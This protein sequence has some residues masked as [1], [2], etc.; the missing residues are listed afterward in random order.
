MR[1]R[2]FRWFKLEQIYFL[3]HNPSAKLPS[4]VISG[5]INLNQEAPESTKSKE[6]QGNLDIDA[7]PFGTCGNRNA[8]H[9]GNNFLVGAILIL[10]VYISAA[11]AGSITIGLCEIDLRRDGEFIRF[12]LVVCFH[13]FYLVGLTGIA[14]SF[15]IFFH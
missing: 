11:I 10:F 2:V 8:D 5:L 15:F 14:G 4:I 3:N 7:Y 6:G 12:R 13:V 1:A 9:G